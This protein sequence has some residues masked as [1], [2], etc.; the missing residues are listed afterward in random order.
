MFAKMKTGTKVLA[1]F[2]LAL[3]VAVIVGSVGYRGVGKLSGHVTE[4]GTVRLPSIQAL[5]EI[6]LGSERI[7]SAQRTLFNLA[8]DTATRLHQ[9]GDIEA[10]RNAY[11]AAWKVY[12][13]LPKTA[14]ED[15][16]WKQFVPA[17]QEWRNDNNEF[18]QLSRQY[19]EMLQKC[20][21]VKE[22]KFSLPDG[23]QDAYKQYTQVLES[24]KNQ[25]QE[26]KNLLLRGSNS[27]DF[28]KHLTE[29]QKQEAAVQAGLVRL[30]SLMNNVGLDTQ[31]VD[32]IVKAHAEL[33]AKYREVIEQFDT[34][35]A[36]AGQKADQAIRGIDSPV[37]AMFDA[38]VKV[39]NDKQAIL[40][41]LESKMVAQS[42]VTCR[43]SQDK[44]NNLLDQIIKVNEDGC[45]LSVQTADSD[46]RAS[47]SMM[48]IAIGLGAIVMS[49]LGVFLAKSVSYAIRT[50]IQGTQRLSQ[51]AVDG[52][53][54]DRGNPE[55]VSSEFR[56]III[57]INNTIEAIVTPLHMARVNLEQIAK[58]NIPPKVTEQYK[59][60]FN[61][62]KNSL[63]ESIDAI[64]GLISEAKLLS[65]A[66]AAGELDV[67]ADDS[68]Y[69]GE[70]RNII[71]GMNDTLKG[72]AVPLQDIGR[73]MQ[74]MA[75]KDFTQEVMTEYPGAYGQFRDN[76]N[77]VI[78]NMR[79]AIEQITESAGQF[80][81]GARTVAESAQS[82][83]QGAQTQSASVEEMTASTEELSR[84]VNTVKENA[85]E[86]TRV[87]TKSNQMAE[88]GGRAVQKSIE[89]ME[90]IRNSSQ[91]ISEI[92]QVI[93]EIASQTNLLALNAAIEAARAGEHGMGFAVVADEVRKLAERSN[94][95]AREI[96]SLIKEST[97]RVE[98]GALLSTQ[99][100]ES[101]K[102]IIKAAEDTASKITEIATATVE[103][104]ANTEEAA[105]AIQGVAKVT[106][107]IAAGSEEM[108]A[109]SEELGA[110]ASA[111][112]E[113]VGQF[114]VEAHR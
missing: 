94:Q 24:Y 86:S 30:K 3:M 76:V 38:I 91:K 111:L 113:L 18:F 5:L 23:L 66:A 29:F 9:Q 68:A 39:I 75:D 45:N 64:N 67:R 80:A 110:Q 20:P 93:S 6:K 98:E 36:E 99:T 32:A 114:H 31:S 84:S 60:D 12:E 42:T 59:G 40:D 71:R 70:Y 62:I 107:Q 54:D 14:K 15:V 96:S 83:A 57:G 52:K 106:E 104:A 72:F 85:N 108:A 63:N 55:L 49:V 34:S 82:L 58:G 92:I 50:L 19:D 100:G 102:Q 4:I 46:G 1:G 41:N 87:A 109:S 11:E 37:T 78:Y 95:A 22:D 33:G 8:A 65:K 112:R 28:D 43:I 101:L 77:L 27:E 16:L 90:Q 105:R 26:W 88:E 73:V 103:Q 10:A 2:G 56:P 74:R 13:K 51:A 44:A 47:T 25:V 48:M 35:N 89:S 69:H 7:K 17:W 79:S 81:E 97:E 21:G 53:L 61:K